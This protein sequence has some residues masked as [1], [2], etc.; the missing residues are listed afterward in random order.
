MDSREKALIRKRERLVLELSEVDNQLKAYREEA[1]KIKVY[2]AS[3]SAIG[4]SG[5]GL[6]LWAAAL[7]KEE[8]RIGSKQD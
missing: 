8:E 5:H 6:A 2:N 4:G 7:I 3:E 1:R